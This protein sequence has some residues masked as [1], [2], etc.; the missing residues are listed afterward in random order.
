MNDTESTPSTSG[1]PSAAAFDAAANK[2]QSLVDGFIAHGPD[3]GDA[4]N[5]MATALA[6]VSARVA[7]QA[8][9]TEARAVETVRSAWQ[10][11]RWVGQGQ[12]QQPAEQ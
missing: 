11:H 9:W 8:G 1:L 3:R 2:L 5:A 4:L 12:E 6:I 7:Q 10:M